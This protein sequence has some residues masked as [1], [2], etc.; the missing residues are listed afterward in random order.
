ADMLHGRA[1]HARGSNTANAGEIHRPNLI[2]HQPI[3]SVGLTD[4]IVRTS[5][6]TKTTRQRSRNVSE[7]VYLDPRIRRRGCGGLWLDDEMTV[8]R[9][10]EGETHSVWKLVIPDNSAGIVD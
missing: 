3:T 7:D 8:G 9:R 5:L 2:A 10:H 4:Q 6:K 1:S